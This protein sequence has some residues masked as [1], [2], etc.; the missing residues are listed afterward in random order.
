MAELKRSSHSADES[1]IR[2]VHVLC[3]TR[4]AFSV[5]VKGDN[6]RGQFVFPVVRL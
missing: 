6:D 5:I 2:K 1:R 4:L 3:L